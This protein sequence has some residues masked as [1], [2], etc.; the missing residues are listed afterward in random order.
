MG[1]LKLEEWSTREK[2]VTIKE[3]EEKIVALISNPN[4]GQQIKYLIETK[5]NEI[6][7]LKKQL[8]IPNVH[9]VQTTEIRKVE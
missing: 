4:D 7:N 5:Y 3:L 8:K 6:Y 1:L 2:Q 9:P